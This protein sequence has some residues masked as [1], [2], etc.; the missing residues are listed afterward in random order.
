MNLE[1]NHT[2]LLRFGTSDDIISATILN[3]SEKAY[4]VRWNN[5]LDSINEWKIKVNIDNRYTLVEDI[6]DFVVDDK[7]IRWL[8]EKECPMCGGSGSVPNLGK[9]LTN[10]TCLCLRCWGSGRVIN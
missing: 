5:G 9:S 7:K 6:T 1:L 3:V 2:Y 10:F 8:E 4:Y